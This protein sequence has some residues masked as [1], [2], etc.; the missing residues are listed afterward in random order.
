MSCDT[1]AGISQS[2]R[3]LEKS[4]GVP[5][6][7]TASTIKNLDDIEVG[8]TFEYNGRE[9]EVTDVNTGCIAGISAM[10]RLSYWANGKFTIETHRKY[11][12][13]KR[14]RNLRFLKD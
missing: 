2:G 8:D 3:C 9:W 11:F 7:A 14:I 13:K 12:Q 5:Q 1:K 6:S 4:D 10:R